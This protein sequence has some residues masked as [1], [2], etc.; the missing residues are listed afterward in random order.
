[1]HI[2]Q[3]SLFENG[4]NPQYLSEQ[5][6]TYLGNKRSLLSFIGIA[7]DI[8]IGELKK[9]KLDIVDM[10]SGS[11][12]VSRFMKQYANTL[13]T[14]D[15][16]Q[17]CFRINN[18]Y[19]AN[20]K[21]TDQ[22]LLEKYYNHIVNKLKNE[23]LREGFIT[24]LYSPMNDDNIQKGERVF[25][26][27][28]NAQYIDT[29]RHYLEEIPEPYKTF[30]LAPLLYEASVHT[31]TSGVFKGF[32]KN[33]V[34]GIGQFGGDGRNALSRILGEINLKMPI[35]SNYNC[36]IQIFK[37]D[38]NILA[39]K[40]PAVDLVYI[41]PPYNQHPY[42]SNYFMLNLIDSYIEPKEVSA[43][44]GIPKEWNKSLYNKKQT[45]KDTMFELCSSLNTKYLLISFNSEGFISK[46][47]MVSL[48][49]KIGEVT[50]FDKEY[51]AFRGS[52]N[53]N[54]RDIHVK[55]FLFLVKTK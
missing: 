53:L 30:L 2:Q 35:F 28:R 47:E 10:F 31:N 41:D 44:S 7:L 42:G 4:E 12:I 20:K 15:M 27:R 16:E 26:S 40:L 23:P 18:C 52:R 1:M 11:G 6:I 25:Y 46:D 36:N 55:E 39:K 50:V 21:E 51:N 22:N 45:V 48:L 38:A 3:L 34:T 54:N 49:S 24:R 14:N 13:Y 29:A 32:Y 8:V 37:E 9:E 19:L 5:I 43:I 17:Y 33:S